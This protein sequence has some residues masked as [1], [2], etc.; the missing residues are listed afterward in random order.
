MISPFVYASALAF[1]TASP[2]VISSLKIILYNSRASGS[3]SER[4]PH[5]LPPRKAKAPLSLA[6]RN[7]SA[8]EGKG[9]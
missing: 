5:G 1:V 7:A 2:N 9:F 4:Y 6:R 8:M 3:W